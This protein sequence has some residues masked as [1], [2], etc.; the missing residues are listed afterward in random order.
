MGLME[1]IVSLCKRRGFIFPSSEIYGGIGSVY[2][3]GHYGVLLKNNVKQ[4]WWQANVLKREEVVGLDSAVILHPRVWQASGHV[5]SFTDPLVEC[6]ECHQRYRADYLLEG[7]YGDIKTIDGKPRCPAC[8]GELTEEKKF[9]LMFKTYIGAVENTA[10]AAYLRPETAQGIFV[11]FKTIMITNSQKI[12]FGIAQI[13]KAF[14]NEITP[15]NFTFRTR[16]FEQMEIEF[17]VE[18]GTDE[19]WHKY[20]LDERIKW[21]QKLGIKKDNLRLRQHT[22]KELS[23]YSKDT[24]DVEYQFPWG[25]GELEGIANRTDF[26]LKEH[27]KYSGRDLTYFDETTKKTYIP[28]VIEPSAGADR[29]TLAFL[30]DSYY[31]DGK[32]IVL[33]LHPQLAPIKVAI[34]PLVANKPDLIRVAKKIYEMLRTQLVVAFDD[35]GNIGKRYYA[36][37]EIG[38]PWCVT[39]DYDTLKDN[40]VTVRDRD[41]TKQE[42]VK[43]EALIAYFNEKL[44]TL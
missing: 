14:R 31:E 11:N 29:A 39:I 15:G 27:Q 38:T 9:N 28:Y 23:H 10:S 18:P 26:D 34:F 12:P 32:R 25:W 41:T 30:I 19:K 20:W 2:D 1:K 33:Q 40:T 13:G 8:G 16:E 43:A 36:Q 22:K 4:L 21:Y 37:D 42:R 35:R 44:K 5:S 24:Y 6:K 3:Y 7:K 17:F